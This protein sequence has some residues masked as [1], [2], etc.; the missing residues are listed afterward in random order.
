[1]SVTLRLLRLQ[2][3]IRLTALAAA[4]IFSCADVNFNLAVVF[5]GAKIR[6]AFSSLSRNLFILDTFF[7][8]Y[9]LLWSD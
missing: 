3:H 6:K 4:E 7:R 2:L 9:D 8:F 5:S 1:M